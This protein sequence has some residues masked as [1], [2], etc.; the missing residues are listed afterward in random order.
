MPE[1]ESVEAFRD[2]AGSWL[3]AHAPRRS[4]DRQDVAEQQVTGAR[5]RD[6]IAAAKRFQAELFEAGLTG[7]RWPRAYGGRELT[8]A[9]EIAFAAAAAPFDLP[10][11]F[12]FSITFGMC[13]PTV[14]AHGT[15]QQKRRYI[16]PMLRGAQIWCQL[17][18]EPGAGSDLAAIRTS[19]VRDG[20]HWVVNGQKVWSSGAHYSDFGLLLART[21]PELPKHRGLTMFVVDMRRPGL[22]IRPLRQMNGAE[23][24]NEVFFDDLRIPADSVVG[25]VNDGW[26]TAI[27]TLMNERVALGGGADS[28][29]QAGVENLFRLARAAGRYDDP[30]VRDRL[31]RTYIEHSI[32]GLIGQRVR[33]AA[34]RGVAPGPEGSIGKLATARSDKGLAA[35]A[36]DLGGARI[37]AWDDSGRD[38]TVWTDLLLSVPARSI[39]GGTDEVQ[40]NIVGDRVLGLPREHEPGRHGPFR[41]RTA[42]PETAGQ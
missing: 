27:T 5:G 4:T 29:R 31:A 6:P 16:E 13:G 22:T 21:A 1:V 36:A 38:C 18:S 34:L 20:D 9:H 30:V 28:D 11:G 10:T 17:F 42:G 37:A 39:A 32:V 12:V 15:E 19:A 33:D 35:L 14:L 24:F 2:R 25:E 7:L 40:K 8:L 3:D 26:R 41:D 23:H